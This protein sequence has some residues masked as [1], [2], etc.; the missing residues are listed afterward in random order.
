MPHIVGSP[1]AR[2]RHDHTIAH[3]SRAGR[4]RTL[5]R[6]W[7]FNAIASIMTSVVKLLRI[8]LAPG[9]TSPVSLVTADPAV[10]LAASE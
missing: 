5:G 6:L 2:R 1:W 8:A 9:G 4:H 7:C 3:T 10:D